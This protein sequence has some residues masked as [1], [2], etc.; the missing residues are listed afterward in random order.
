M[1]RRSKRIAERKSRNR[2]KKPGKEEMD[3]EIGLSSQMSV[4]RPRNRKKA[5]LVEP[6]P[7]ER[8]RSKPPALLAS[9]NVKRTR[10]KPP[11]LLPLG[12]V[13]RTHSK[14]PPLLPSANGKRTRSKASLLARD[15]KADTTAPPLL[16]NVLS[17]IR[18]VLSLAKRKE[19]SGD[20]RAPLEKGLNENSSDIRPPLERPLNANKSAPPSKASIEDYQT[21]SDDDDMWEDVDFLLAADYI[22]WK[23]GNKSLKNYNEYFRQYN[24][25]IR[26]IFKHG[27]ILN[28]SVFFDYYV[29]LRDIKKYV[30]STIW[31][32]MS[33]VKAVYEY[34]NSDADLSSYNKVWKEMKR[35]SKQLCF[36]YLFL[37]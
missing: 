19:V 26:Y 13:E 16:P 21:P 36:L 7:L 2:K 10:S 35:A 28:E 18:P 4:F 1:P 3:D 8:T 17:N 6:P 5:Y 9:Q 22:V 33:M 32:Y 25:F 34:I 11:P 23:K 15:E 37:C 20:I 30:I 14:A 12:N 31:T 29:Y 24:Y 27:C